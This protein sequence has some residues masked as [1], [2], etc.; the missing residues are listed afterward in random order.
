MF[1]TISRLFL[2]NPLDWMLKRAARKGGKKILLGWNRGLGDIALG[3]YA[4]VQRI[5]HYIPDAEITFLTRENLREGFSLLEE[6]KTICIPEW[7]RGENVSVKEVARQLGLTW[8][9][10][11]EKPSPTDWVQWQLGQVVPRLK[12]NKQH[13]ALHE[14]FN[15]SPDFTYIGVQVMAETN[16]GPWRN[17]PLERWEELFRR[18]E[19]R[20]K[21]KILLFGYGKKP[22][23]SH[24]NLIDLRGKTT[25]FELL[26]LIKNRCYALVLPDSGIAAMSY[27]LDESFPLRHITLW[28]DPTQGILKQRV[29]SPNPQLIHTALIAKNRDLTTI[30]VDDVLSQLFPPKPLNACADARHI[31]KESVSRTGCILLAGGQG[32]R[33]GHLGPKGLFPI[34]GKTLFEWACAKIPKEAPLAVMTSPLNHAETVAYFQAHNNFGLDVSFFSQEMQ[35]LCDDQRRPLILQAPN[36]NGNVFKAFV[37]AG[38]AEH[39]AKKGI[40]FLSI[41]YV[42]NPL[43]EPFDPALITHT[44]RE[45]AEVTIQ[46]IERLEQYRS[47]GVLVQRGEQTEIVEYTELDPSQNYPFAYSGQLI[48]DFAFF[49]KMADVAL[50]LHWVRKRV[51]GRWLWKGEQFIFDALPYAASVRAVCVPHETSYAPLKSPEHIAEVEKRLKERLCK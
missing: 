31:E 8:D 40:E 6:V 28:A 43:A 1:R 13:D 23:L 4:I 33:L 48:F 2:P 21:V 26:S 39:F 29:N 51:D 34:A 3:L 47:M 50:P 30:S 46:C 10:L 49:C 17:W 45:K 15:L 20:K 42:E 32:T 9:L 25:L 41:T 14:K 24:P 16:H 12:W 18:L 36:G 38:L 35:P 5:R 27:Y 22:Q 44:R 7:R 19:R 11:I 37:K